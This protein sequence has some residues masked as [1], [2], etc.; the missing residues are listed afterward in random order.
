MNTIIEQRK[1]INIVATPM[2]N[3]GIMWRN[4]HKCSMKEEHKHTI[5][6]KE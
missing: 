1:N 5:S 4:K 3:M 2:K 6:A